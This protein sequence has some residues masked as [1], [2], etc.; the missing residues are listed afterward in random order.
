MSALTFHFHSAAAARHLAKTMLPIPFNSLLAPATNLY[1]LKLFIEFMCH[2][3]DLQTAGV[4]PGSA[5][6]SDGSMP[7]PQLAVKSQM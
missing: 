7:E 3:G 1:S 4:S 2:L 5:V 6:T